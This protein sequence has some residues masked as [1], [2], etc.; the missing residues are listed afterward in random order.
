M[1]EYYRNA[2]AVLSAYGASGCND[3]MSLKRSCLVSPPFG[4]GRK[5]CLRL[6]T[7]PKTDLARSPISKRAWT[8]QERFFAYRIMHFLNDQIMC[9]CGEY[10][11]LESHFQS[12]FRT[13]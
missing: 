8:L 1:A 5:L 11:R 13:E 6:N 9:E 4:K 7:D 2:T 3:G 12:D 10:T